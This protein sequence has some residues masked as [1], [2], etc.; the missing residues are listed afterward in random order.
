MRL[1][2]AMLILFV[3][4]LSAGTSLAATYYVATNGNDNNDGSSGTPS[5]RS[6]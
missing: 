6:S 5:I 4:L 3:V 1:R 2:V